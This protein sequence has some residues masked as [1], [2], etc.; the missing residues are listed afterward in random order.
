MSPCIAQLSQTTQ[1][2][3][4]YLSPKDLLEDRASSSL[5]IERPPP[6]VQARI[7]IKLFHPQ[8][9]LDV[10]TFSASSRQDHV[11]YLDGS[12]CSVKVLHRSR[13]NIGAKCCRSTCLSSARSPSGSAGSK[14]DLG[15]NCGDTELS[16]DS[17]RRKKFTPAKNVQVKFIGPDW[18]MRNF[19]PHLR[20]LLLK[21]T[22]FVDQTWPPKET[23]QRWNEDRYW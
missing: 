21:P 20:D 10:R 6:S 11:A 22:Q 19:Q 15:M 14:Q 2:G 5:H 13:V 3:I 7:V 23:S 17:L 1:Q 16:P 4:L 18:P 12:I 9:S 8:T